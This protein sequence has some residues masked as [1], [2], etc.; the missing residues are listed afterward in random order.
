MGLPRPSDRFAAA[1]VLALALA[2]S[3]AG[4]SAVADAIPKGGPIPQNQAEDYARLSSGMSTAPVSVVSSRLSTYGAERP[5]GTAAK[6]GDKVWVVV[7]SGMFPGASLC[8]I[9][10]PA[11]S[12]SLTST[13]APYVNS[14]PP[15]SARERVILDANWG[16]TLE[17]LPGA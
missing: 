10:I 7:L 17:V 3:L 9:P 5:R 6:P 16:T 8:L 11:F 15:P 12:F 14:C 4:C 13:P 2:S 1:V